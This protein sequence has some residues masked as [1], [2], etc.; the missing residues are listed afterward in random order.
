MYTNSNSFTWALY[1]ILKHPE[2]YNLVSEEVLE[3][4][5][6]INEQISTSKAKT[7]LKYLEVA[8]LEI[9]RMNT[10]ASR[11]LARVLPE[12]GISVGGYYLPENV[13]YLNFK[14]NLLTYMTI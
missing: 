12:G 8:I 2:I 14:N 4:F 7:E 13:I 1:K 11:A 10:T 3:K 5:P 9:M 6:D